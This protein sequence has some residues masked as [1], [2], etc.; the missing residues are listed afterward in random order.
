M[1]VQIYLRKWMI[2]QFRALRRYLLDLLCFRDPIFLCFMC[3]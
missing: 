1:G 3:F 2:D